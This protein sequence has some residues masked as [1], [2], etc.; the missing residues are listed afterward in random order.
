[1]IYRVTIRIGHAKIYFDFNS[2]IDAMTFMDAAVRNVS[3]TDG[4]G[5]EFEVFLSMKDDAP[6][7]DQEP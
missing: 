4:D 5:R 3:G 2:A 6:T 1:M 7:A